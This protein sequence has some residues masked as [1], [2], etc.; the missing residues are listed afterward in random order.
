LGFEVHVVCPKKKSGDKI[1]TAIHDFEGDQTY[2]EKPGHS[3]ALNFD[4]DSVVLSEYA[5]LVLPGGRS[6]EYLRLD[7]K[8]LEYTNHFVSTNK[9][10]LS[11]CHGI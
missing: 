8:V 3:F 7:A 4:F 1:K 10:I 11:I 6:P 9:P 5:G 2:T